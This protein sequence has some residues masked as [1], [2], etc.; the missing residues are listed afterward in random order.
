[1]P[2][3]ALG[4]KICRF[5]HACMRRSADRSKPCVHCNRA[6]AM[7]TARR[8]RRPRAETIDSIGLV[9]VVARGNNIYSPVSWACDA[10][11]RLAS[12]RRCGLFPVSLGET[13]AVGRQRRRRMHR[14]GH[15]HRKEVGQRAHWACIYIQCHLVH[16]D[17][18]STGR[19]YGVWWLDRSAGRAMMGLL[20]HA[21]GATA[22]IT[23]GSRSFESREQKHGGLEEWRRSREDL[24]EFESNR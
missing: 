5:P 14:S 21:V 15:C 16:S 23:Y 4:F 18:Y 19:L 7:Q 9:C 13:W 6:H 22:H 17:F 1:M 3:R 24:G 12:G 20:L 2:D 11:S 10:R 8:F